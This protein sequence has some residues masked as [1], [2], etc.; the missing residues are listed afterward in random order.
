MGDE[1]S[2]SALSAHEFRILVGTPRHK[3]FSNTVRVLYDQA[4]RRHAR[5]VGYRLTLSSLSS[6]CV[7]VD[8]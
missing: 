1:Q 7:C 5:W 3:V 2:E 8:V 4:D 6:V